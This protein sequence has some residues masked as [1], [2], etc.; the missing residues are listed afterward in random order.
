MMR[1]LLLCKRFLVL[2]FLCA[3]AQNAYGSVVRIAP[4]VR[5][6]VV[7]HCDGCGCR[8]VVVVGM[9]GFLRDELFASWVKEFWC[10]ENR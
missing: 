9:V 8:L 2:G 5:D 6:S 3:Q 10:S 7:G 1:V 4:S